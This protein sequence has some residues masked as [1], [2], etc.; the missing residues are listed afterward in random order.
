MKL[1]LNKI[2]TLANN[3]EY[4]VIN[5]V[6]YEETDYYYIA[7]VNETGDNIKDNYKIVYVSVENGEKLLNEVTGEDKLKMI[8]PLFLE[9]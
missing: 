8:L 6:S 7:E 1:E 9:D 5:T 4:L 3:E 2:I